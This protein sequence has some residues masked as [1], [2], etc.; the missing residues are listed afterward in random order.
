M[1]F[2]VVAVIAILAVYGMFSWFHVPAPS[3]DEPTSV[4]NSTEGLQVVN[5]TAAH[6]AKGDLVISGD[7]VNAIDQ[8][9]PAWLVVAEIFDAQGK[10]LGRA[11][12]LNGKELYTRRDYEILAKRGFD[13][14]GLKARNLQD[15]S[16]KIP[17]KGT[18]HFDITIIEAP[19][20]IANF[21]AV[22]QP[23]DPV[24]LFKEITEEQKQP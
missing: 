18:V 16:V 13:V 24:Q 5:T 7:V 15:Q 22:L 9:R 6:N 3:R 2:A 23:F 20:G 19:V 8:E 14:Q 21:N 1:V 10:Q 4:L 12:L 17:P 11:K